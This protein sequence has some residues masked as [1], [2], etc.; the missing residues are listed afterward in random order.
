MDELLRETLFA[1]ESGDRDAFATLERLHARLEPADSAGY[2]RDMAS[3]IVHSALDAALVE[4][5]S[6]PSCGQAG[7]CLDLERRRGMWHDALMAVMADC[8]GKAARSALRHGVGTCLWAVNGRTTWPDM[9]SGWDKYEPRHGDDMASTAT[10]LAV[11]TESG[12]AAVAVDVRPPCRGSWGPRIAWPS[13]TPWQDVSKSFAGKLKA[14]GWSDHLAK[15]RAL[16]FRTSVGHAIRWSSQEADRVEAAKGRL[17]RVHTCQGC[18]AWTNGGL[19][20][21]HEVAAVMCRDCR[22]VVEELEAAT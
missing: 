2:V 7:G 22:K 15:E 6:T 4:H 10:T 8:A 5:R 9:D 12:S 14:W 11:V 17:V 18:G 1:A 3:I 16:A 13:L 20:E 19:V 21:R